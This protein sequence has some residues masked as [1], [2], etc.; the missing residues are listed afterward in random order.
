MSWQKI[1]W[2]SKI[3]KHEETV[4][5]EEKCKH[6]SH[7]WIRP[8]S[9][10]VVQSENYC[11]VKIFLHW[12]QIDWK[13]SF[14]RR[15]KNAACVYCPPWWR[16]RLAKYEM[17]QSRSTLKY[18]VSFNIL[19]ITFWFFLCRTHLASFN[20]FSPIWLKHFIILC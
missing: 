9:I 10:S 14:E 15:K 17:N 7:P 3:K 16:S 1:A 13:A 6:F 20:Q 4:Y 5:A 18:S 11:S 8:K 2:N 19:V 12:C